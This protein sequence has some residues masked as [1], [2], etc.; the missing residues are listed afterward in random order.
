MRKIKERGRVLRM[1]TN[2][3]SSIK[4][5]KEKIAITLKNLCKYVQR[6]KVKKL[7]RKIS[8]YLYI[9]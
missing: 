7:H 9:E 4:S 3:I 2:H 1:G 6:S 8:I 5:R